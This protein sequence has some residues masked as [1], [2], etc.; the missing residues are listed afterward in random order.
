M[1]GAGRRTTHSRPARDELAHVAGSIAELHGDLIRRG[2]IRRARDLSADVIETFLRFGYVLR[3]L[4][5]AFA[6]N[7]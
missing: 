4:D 1:V 7:T 6:I 5:E 2:I 3:C